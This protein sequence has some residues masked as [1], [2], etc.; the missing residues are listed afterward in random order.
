MK[1]ITLIIYSFIG[2]FL[3]SCSTMKES[4]ATDLRVISEIHQYPTVTDLNVLQ[5]VDTV[6]SWNYTPFNFG[7][8]S[9]NNRETNL[10]A[11]IIKSN[12]ADV[13]LEKQVVYTKVPYGTRTLTVTGY[14]AKFKDFRKATKEDLEALRAIAPTQIQKKAVYQASESNSFF[15]KMKKRFSKK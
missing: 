4:T 9:L 8:P 7:Q 1:R 2:L 5:K 3:S 11:D 6:I 10:V 12:G 15:T 14:P 13:L